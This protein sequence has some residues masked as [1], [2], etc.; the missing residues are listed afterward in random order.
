MLERICQLRVALIPFP[1]SPP[2]LFPLF[3]AE[4]FVLADAADAISA[5][6]AKQRQKRIKV[7]QQLA[8]KDRTPL[9]AAGDELSHHQRLEQ[10]FAQLQADGVIQPPP[11]PSVATGACKGQTDLDVALNEPLSDQ[12]KVYN[13]RK[14][15]IAQQQ[16]ALAQARECA[17]KQ[18]EQE[19]A[20]RVIGLLR[21]GELGTVRV[22]LPHGN[23]QRLDYEAIFIFEGELTS[24]FGVLQAQNIRPATDNTAGNA[25][26]HVL[27]SMCMSQICF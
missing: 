6:D 13:Q 27:K 3:I 7:K 23:H 18:A 24:R 15:E 17:T 12:G 22:M 26:T 14:R 20:V 9:S 19:W 1:M 5:V 2:A 16:K 10:H 8:H 11:L 21:S 25:Y 4:R